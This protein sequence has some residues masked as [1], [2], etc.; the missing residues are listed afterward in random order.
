VRQWSVAK[1]NPPFQSPEHWQKRAEEAKAAAELLKDPASRIEMLRI[2]EGYGRLAERSR[3]NSDA[4]PKK[5][6]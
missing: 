2:A 5:M 3:N 1:V 6:S 4:T